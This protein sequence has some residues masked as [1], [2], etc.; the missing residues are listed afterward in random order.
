[1]ST[2]P[3]FVEKVLELLDPLDVTAKPMFGEYGLYLKG[4]LFGLICD[5][6]LF[7]K[8]TD[9]GSEIAGKSAKASPYPGA[10]LAFKISSA[11]LRDELWLKQLVEAT[12]KALPAPKPKKKSGL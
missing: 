6:M 11:R 2:K 9:E 3:T 10:K 1:M 5:D 12:T 4:K 7:I 8:I